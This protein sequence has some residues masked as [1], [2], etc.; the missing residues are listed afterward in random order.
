MKQ[1]TIARLITRS[2]LII[3]SLAIPARGKTTE[4]LNWRQLAELPPIK[5]QTIQPGLAGDFC[6]IHND[7][8]IIAGGA[9]FPRPIWESK[10]VWH[11]DIYVLIK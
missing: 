7:A 3:A 11:D 5:G 4:V 6:G 9:N 1:N 8:L 2:L 10:K